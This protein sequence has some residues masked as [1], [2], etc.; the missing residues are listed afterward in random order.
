MSCQQ[1]YLASYAG[2]IRPPSGL[3]LGSK[4]KSRRERLLHSSLYLL[5]LAIPV[6][7]LWSKTSLLSCSYSSTLALVSERILTN[8]SQPIHELEVP[9][10]NIQLCYV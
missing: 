2:R 5:A 10:L 6:L 8:T 4:V 1:S 7:S 3:T 9:F